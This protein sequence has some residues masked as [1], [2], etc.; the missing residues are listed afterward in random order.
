MHGHAVALEMWVSVPWKPDVTSCDFSDIN[1]LS[2]FCSHKITKPN[3]LAHL[4]GTG[5]PEL[6]SELSTLGLGILILHRIVLWRLSVPQRISSHI[7]T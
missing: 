3:V 4:N 7:V 2:A 5:P 1:D 6:F